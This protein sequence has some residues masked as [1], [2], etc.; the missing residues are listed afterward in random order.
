M[1]DL[2]HHHRVQLDI[3][4]VPSFLQ[5]N[6]KSLGHYGFKTFCKRISSGVKHYYLVTL[7]FGQVL[8]NKEP[9]KKKK[10][11]LSYELMNTLRYLIPFQPIFLFLTTQSWLSLATATRPDQW[12]KCGKPKSNENGI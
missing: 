6:A 3:R 12:A 9:K 7:V 5:T 8:K 2:K 1:E 4:Y 11:I 10:R